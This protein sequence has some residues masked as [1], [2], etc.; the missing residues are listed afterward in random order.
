MHRL[1]SLVSMVAL[2]AGSLPAQAADDRPSEPVMMSP[3]TDHPPCSI[4]FRVIDGGAHLRAGPGKDNP[5]MTTLPAG[6]VVVGCETRNGWEGVIVGPDEECGHDIM[7]S[8]RRP[9]DGPCPSGWIWQG[10]LV[11]IFG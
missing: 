7:L 9:Y 1:L 4:G 11:S 10:R 8:S 5:V 2:V 3:D 6:T